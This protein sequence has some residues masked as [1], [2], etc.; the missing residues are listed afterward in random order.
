MRWRFQPYCLYKD[1]AD[2]YGKIK[3]EWGFKQKLTNKDSNES[4]I[5]NT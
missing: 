2:K 4:K 5:Y 3:N 1:S